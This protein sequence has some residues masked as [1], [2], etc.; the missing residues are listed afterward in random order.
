MALVPLVAGPFLR[1]SVDALDRVAVGVFAGSLA[2]VLVLIAV[3]V[4]VLGT[5][6]PYALRLS[7]RSVEHA[8]TVAGRL[9][10]ISTLGSLAGVFISALLL[11]PLAGTRR[12]FLVFALAL[13]LVA[14]PALSKRWII[15]PVAVLGLLFLP[16]ATIKASGQGRVSASARRST[17]TPASCSTPT[18][19]A[20]SNSTRARRCIRHGEPAVT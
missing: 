10:A 7:V 11:I 5:V 6:A 17:N 9:Y 15:I 19:N 1:V 14:V 13:A 3:P 20:S 2:A 16:T 4:M 8:G 12:T 18:A